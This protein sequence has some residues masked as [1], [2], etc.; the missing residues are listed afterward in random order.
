MARQTFLQRMRAILEPSSEEIITNKLLGQTASAFEPA[1]S[2]AAHAAASN[3]HPTYLT[4]TEGDALYEDAGA[5]AA[6][7]AAGNPHPT[8]LT[9]AEGDALY[10][11][12]VSGTA[13]AGVT[14]NTSPHVISNTWGRTVEIHVTG[15]LTV[16]LTRD[17][18]SVSQ[19]F[20]YVAGGTA[21]LLRPDSTLTVTWVT[22]PTA[23]VMIL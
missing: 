11:P 17:T 2:V 1:G 15:G 6:H 7:E 8:Y 13:P 22:K 23:T 10:A 20:S 21:V 16:G 5:V 3:P 12:I 14:L 18:D 4:Q 9:Q 19:T